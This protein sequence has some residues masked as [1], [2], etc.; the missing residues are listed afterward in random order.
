MQ[1]SLTSTR[2]RA[3]IISNKHNRVGS[4]YDYENLYHTFDNL[5]FVTVGAHRNYTAQ[6]CLAVVWGIGSYQF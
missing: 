6:V 4:E 5:G 1:Y 3:L 2:G